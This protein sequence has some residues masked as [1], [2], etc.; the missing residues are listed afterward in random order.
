MILIFHFKCT[1]K[2]LQF[3]FN[4]NQS[5]ILLSGSGLMSFPMLYQLYD[6][7]NCTFTSF[8]GILFT[9]TPHNILSK[10]LAAFP[11]NHC[12]KIKQQWERNEFCCNNYHQFLGRILA[13]PRDRTIDLLFSSPVCYP[14]S[15]GASNALLKNNAIYAPKIK[16]QHTVFLLGAPSLIV[17]PP[18]EKSLNHGN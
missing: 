6:G 4:L 3:V 14:L 10:T 8:P 13:E 15:Y 5:K 7:S 18:Q 1:L 12:T 16:A 2:C 9:S 11:H 17:A